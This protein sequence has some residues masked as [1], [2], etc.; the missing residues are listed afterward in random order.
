MERR[1]WPSATSDSTQIPEAS[2]PRCHSRAFKA[3]TVSRRELSPALGSTMPQ[4][5]HTVAGAIPEIQVTFLVGQKWIC[6][7]TYEIFF[8]LS[9]AVLR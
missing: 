6:E 5:P 3:V 2:G 8:T 7:N 9:D 1:V 4:I